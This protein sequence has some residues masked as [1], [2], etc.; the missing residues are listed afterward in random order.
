MVLHVNDFDTS[1]KHYSTH[2]I[3]AVLKLYLYPLLDN[4]RSI[5]FVWIYNKTLLI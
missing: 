1:V 5:K 4:E 2:Q 3:C